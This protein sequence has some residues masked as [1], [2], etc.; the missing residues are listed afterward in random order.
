MITIFRSCLLLLFIFA[1]K[2]DSSEKNKNSKNVKPLFKDL[3]IICDTC[4]STIIVHRNE[5][6]FCGEISVDSGSVFYTHKILN[7]IDTLSDNADQS[8]TFHINHNL[9]SLK[10]LSIEQTPFFNLQNES[11]ENS[12]FQ[13]KFRLTGTVVDVKRRALGNGVTEAY[14]S[15][16]FKI[17][18][19][20]EV[21]N[22]A[23][24]KRSK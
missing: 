9:I 16:V 23:F 22:T 17:T 14:P 5:C 7:I 20:I 21:A 10:E 12:E 2:N 18:S 19:K 11:I 1:C 4:T 13:K 8:D 6:I 3:F 15:L 24:P